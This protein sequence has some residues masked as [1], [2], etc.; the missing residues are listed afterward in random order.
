ME[1]FD[2]IMMIPKDLASLREIADKTR[3]RS[4]KKE[5]HSKKYDTRC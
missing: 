3:P 1:E 4:G 5:S 2:V